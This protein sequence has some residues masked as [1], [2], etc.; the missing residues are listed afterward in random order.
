M[1]LGYRFVLKLVSIIHC[2]LEGHHPIYFGAST[3]H[4][5]LLEGTSVL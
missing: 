2:T 5:T 4:R 1:G 3:P